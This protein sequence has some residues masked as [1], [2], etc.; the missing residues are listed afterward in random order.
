MIKLS[1]ILHPTDFSDHSEQA[2][3]YACVLAGKLE[4]ELHLV[5][6]LSDPAAVTSPYMA[7][8]LPPDFFHELKQQ[9]D[10][11]L[12]ELSNK[13]ICENI[14]VIRA[15]L[16][17]VVFREIIQYAREND[18][19][20]IVM[21]THGLSGLMHLIVGSVAENVVRKASCP[22]LT[23]RPDDHEFVMP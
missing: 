19:D 21:G 1:R 15:A 7:S 2:F 11:Q 8:F 5:H 4:A 13:E 6:V 9:S 12:A 23:V 16:E 20:M 10:K 14:T 3:E 18:I 17:G 22:V